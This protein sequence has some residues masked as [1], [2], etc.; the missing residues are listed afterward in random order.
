[1]FAITGT[2]SIYNK[3]SHLVFFNIVKFW[4]R[5]TKNEKNVSAKQN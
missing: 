3:Q 4:N 2:C 5:D 1:M